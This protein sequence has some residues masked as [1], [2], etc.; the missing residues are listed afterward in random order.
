MEHPAIIAM[1]SKYNKTAAQVLGRW[2]IQR[3]IIMVAK[4]VRKERML[5]NM[6]LF[7]F[8]LSDEVVRVPPPY[9]PAPT[10]HM[11]HLC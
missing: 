10:G 9:D 3:N 1:A 4:T 11:L 5:E 7:D 6:S 8:T 2:C